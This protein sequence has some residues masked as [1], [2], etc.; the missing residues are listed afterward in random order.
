MPSISME[1]C[2]L[3]LRGYVKTQIPRLGASKSFREESRNRRLI[4]RLN[5]LGLHDLA[6]ALLKLKKG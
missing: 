3:L 6:L 1:E 5:Y 4:M 2:L